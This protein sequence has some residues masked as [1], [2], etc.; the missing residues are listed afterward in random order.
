MRGQPK[1]TP[2][3]LVRIEYDYRGERRISEPLKPNEAKKLYIRLMNQDRNP[4]IKK[5]SDS[6][7]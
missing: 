6:H 2:S 5:D 4:E 3:T 1:N 7:A